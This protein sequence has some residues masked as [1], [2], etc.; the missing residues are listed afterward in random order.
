MLHKA[1]EGAI[2]LETFP[3]TTVDIFAL[4]LESG[5]SECF[6]SLH[7]IHCR[8]FLSENV[9]IMPFIDSIL[10]SLCLLLYVYKHYMFWMERNSRRIKQIAA[11]PI[12][13]S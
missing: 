9:T 12:I 2:I 10:V 8:H 7:F 13:L 5:G 3:K 6:L 4:V 11:H 1:L